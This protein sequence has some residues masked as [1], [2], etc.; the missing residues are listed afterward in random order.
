MDKERAAG[1]LLPLSY[2][3]PH[4]KDVA[5]PPVRHNATYVEPAGSISE[6]FPSQFNITARLSWKNEFDINKLDISFE[7]EYP[8]GSRPT[9]PTPL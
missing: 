6:I 3:C 4:N 9:S 2:I 1:S 5:F 8:P 7:G